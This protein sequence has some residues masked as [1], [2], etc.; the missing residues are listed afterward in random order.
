LSP[1]A[2]V[3]IFLFVEV[4]MVVLLDPVSP[5]VRVPLMAVLIGFCLTYLTSTPWF[6]RRNRRWDR[7]QRS[8]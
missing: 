1:W 7:H 2:F 5:W 3:P 4:G 8:Q 6:A